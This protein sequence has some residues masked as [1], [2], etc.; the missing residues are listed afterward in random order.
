MY[1]IF[2][3]LTAFLTRKEFADK[4]IP[5]DKIVGSNIASSSDHQP[6]VTTCYFDLN[7]KSWYPL[8]YTES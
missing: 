7:D 3:V 6:F 4:Y 1:L 5:L 8:E 2:F